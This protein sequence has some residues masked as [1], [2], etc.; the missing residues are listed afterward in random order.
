MSCN[1]ISSMQFAVVKITFEHETG[2]PAPD[3]KEVHA[4][5]DKLKSRFRVV[6]M[7]ITTV[8]EDGVTA[9]AY[10]SLA[11]SSDALSRQLDAI[12]EFCE[13]QGF[14]RIADEAVLMDDIDSIGESDSD[15]DDTPDNS[16]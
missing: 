7:P 15:D 6:A 2:S 13:S 16:H 14:G 3:R 9:I 12:A 8:E 11:I 4:F 5:L 10:T 1:S